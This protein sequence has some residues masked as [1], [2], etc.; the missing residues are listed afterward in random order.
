[1]FCNQ[2]QLLRSTAGDDKVFRKIFAYFLYIDRKV[3]IGKFNLSVRVSMV[4]YF[5]KLRIQN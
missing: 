3:L 1:M 4:L 2:P 5:C